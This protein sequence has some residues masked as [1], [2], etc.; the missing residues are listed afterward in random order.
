MLCSRELAACCDWAATQHVGLHRAVPAQSPCPLTPTARIP[1]HASGT[2]PPGTLDARSPCPVRDRRGS[3]CARAHSKNS[4][5]YCEENLLLLGVAHLMLSALIAGWAFSAPP[6]CT[7][8]HRVA[9]HATQQCG[10]NA[11]RAGGS[12]AA[13]MRGGA[14]RCR[15]AVTPRAAVH[16]GSVGELAEHGCVLCGHALTQASRGRSWQ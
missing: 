4:G 3:C 10:H 6:R 8:L 13:A 5:R 9:P 16:V 14:R 15:L 1:R 12:P 7:A 2:H 11:P